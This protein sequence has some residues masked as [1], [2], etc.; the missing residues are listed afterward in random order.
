M[1]YTSA[2]QIKKN[3]KIHVIDKT[4]SWILRETFVYNYFDKLNR[5]S[6]ILDIGCGNGFFLRKLKE[7]GFK[8]LYGA[9]IANYLKNKNEFPL[10][11]VDLN[12]ENLPYEDGSFDVV[13]AF[14]VLEHLENYFLIGRDVARI[15]KPGGFFIFSIPNQFN[16][17]YRI[18]F[19]LTG[20]MTGFEPDGNHL[21]FTTRDTFKKT[22]LKNFDIVSKFYGKGPIPMLGRLSFIPGL[23]KMPPKVKILPRCEAFAYK[24]CYVLKK[25]DHF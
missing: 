11:V 23:R 12:K 2:K 1:A 21:L 14:Q 16:I 10:H 17:F 6:K 24:T 13:T 7:M 5:D 3:P 25:K 18:K 22:Y 20:N 19:V 15:L 8:K 9:D 4:V